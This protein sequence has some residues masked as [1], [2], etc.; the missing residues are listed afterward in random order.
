MNVV[1]S[2]LITTSTCCLKNVTLLK[3]WCDLKRIFYYLKISN[4]L[5]RKNAAYHTLIK[6]LFFQSIPISFSSDINFHIRKWKYLSKRSEIPS[7]SIC[8]HRMTTGNLQL[9]FK[10]C[11]VYNECASVPKLFLSNNINHFLSKQSR[12]N[13]QVQTTGI[14][15]FSGQQ[16]RLFTPTFYGRPI[17][18]FEPDI[19]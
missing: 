5:W 12:G 13:N 19:W 4:F 14:Y 3:H 8:L 11:F 9:T 16:F 2:A 1:N 10:F 15:N 7:P 18:Y 17:W 6:R